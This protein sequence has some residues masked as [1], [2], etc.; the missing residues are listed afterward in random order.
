MGVKMTFRII[1]LNQAA[2]SKKRSPQKID[3]RADE[4]HESQTTA[5]ELMSIWCPF[6]APYMKE[7]KLFY[8]GFKIVIIDVKSYMTFGARIT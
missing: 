8:I 6:D 4:T 3:F 2:D 7:F 1:I 5:L